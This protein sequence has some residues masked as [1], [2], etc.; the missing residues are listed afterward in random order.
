M[1]RGRAR[2]ALGGR[3]LPR[4]RHLLRNVRIRAA[5]RLR[6]R[7]RLPRRLRARQLR[8]AGAVALEHDGAAA[9]HLGRQHAAS[10]RGPHGRAAQPARLRGARRHRARRDDRGGRPEG[11]GAPRRLRGKRVVRRARHRGRDDRHAF[12]GL[13]I[14]ECKIHADHARARQPDPAEAEKEGQK[15]P[16]DL[17][18]RRACARRLRRPL[19][20]RHRHLRGHPQDRHAGRHEGLHQAA[21]REKRHAVRAGHAARHGREIHRPARGRRRE[22]AP[23][24]RRGVAEGQ[25]ARARRSQGHRQRAH[26]ALRAAHEAEG[27]RL[28]RGHRL[29]A[30]LRSPF[31][32]QRDGGPAPLHQRD[33]KRHGARRADGPPALR[34]R[35]LR[36][37]R[38]RAARGVQV[39]DGRQAVRDPRA[40]D[41]PRLAALPDR[42]KA[43]GGLPGRHRAALALPH[44]EAAGRD[45][46]Q[47]EARQHRPDRRHAP[48]CLQGRAVQGPRPRHHRRGAALRRPAEGAP[49]GGL[50]VGRRADA[51]GDADPPHAEHGAL[52]HPRHVG[53]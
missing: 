15:Q 35:R 46:A 2:P 39:R 23:P 41:D 53:H 45:P 48:A 25:D 31:R 17:Q 9:L 44:A 40:D 42:F 26:H 19:D 22:A 4:A 49:Q 16:R 1:G 3:A 24:R 21:L 10:G 38:G 36:Q 30:R 28:P 11:R 13:R 29:A 18:P 47:A 14:P 52:R 12:G 7:E 32:I 5:A 50:Q 27:L 51:F 33:Q 8:H 34:R 37:N 6:H 43:H 20:A